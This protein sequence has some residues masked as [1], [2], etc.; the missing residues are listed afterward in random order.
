VTYA[1][2]GFPT[3]PLIDP[4]TGELMPAWRAFF[5][6]LWQRTGS[7]P[8]VQANDGTALS[9]SLAS[10]T[11]ARTAGDEALTAGIATERAARQ[12]ADQALQS[13][14]DVEA[15]QRQQAIGYVGTTML[16]VANLRSQWSALDL[17]GLPHIDPGSGKPWLDG[18]VV[19]VGS[20]DGPMELESEAGRWLRED[21]TGAWSFG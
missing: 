12:A 8:G 17:S 18:N 16:T 13:A 7:A 2:A 14:I 3:G 20:G 9:A 4:A 10:E 6:A 15:M 11:A 19:S 21:G 5:L 1:R